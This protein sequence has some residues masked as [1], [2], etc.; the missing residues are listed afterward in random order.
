MAAEL[1]TYGFVSGL[2]YSSLRKV[3]RSQTTRLYFSLVTAMLSGRVVW[4]ITKAL[5]LG[6]GGKAFTLMAFLTGGFTDALIGIIIQLIL[7]PII[8][9]IYEKTDK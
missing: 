7:V 3:I 2:L 9:K 1:M 6:I 8:V 4:G 5:L